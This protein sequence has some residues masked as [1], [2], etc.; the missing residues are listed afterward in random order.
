MTICNIEKLFIIVCKNPYVF[1]PY[2]TNFLSSL[3]LANGAILKSIAKCNTKYRPRGLVRYNIILK[4][5][6]WFLA[7]KGEKE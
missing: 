4:F 2:I 1:K 3:F 5:S 6:F 7:G